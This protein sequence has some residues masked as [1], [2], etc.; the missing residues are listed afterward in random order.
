MEAFPKGERFS[1]L[2]TTGHVTTLKRLWRTAETGK[3]IS[4]VDQAKTL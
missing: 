1:F 3:R 4:S 2:A